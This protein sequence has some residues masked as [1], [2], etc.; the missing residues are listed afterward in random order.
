MANKNVYF[1]TIFTCLSSKIAG[2]SSTQTYPFLAC[3]QSDISKISLYK[4]LYE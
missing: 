1:V 2:K 3:S 4:Q